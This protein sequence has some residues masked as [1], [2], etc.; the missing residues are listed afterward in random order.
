MMP[1][2]VLERVLDL[3]SVVLEWHFRLVSWL[4]FVLALT[5]P[6]YYYRDLNRVLVYAQYDPF[7]QLWDCEYLRPARV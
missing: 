6:N 2:Y 7:R 4:S 1:T 5:A 3:S